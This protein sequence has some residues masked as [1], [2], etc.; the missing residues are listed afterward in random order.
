MLALVFSVTSFLTATLLSAQTPAQRVLLL[1]PNFSGFCL[2]TNDAGQRGRAYFQSYGQ[3]QAKL[4]IDRE[5][6]NWP[7]PDGSPGLSYE[8]FSKCGGS[9]TACPATNPVEKPEWH[10]NLITSITARPLDLELSRCCRI[11][12]TSETNIWLERGTWQTPGTAAKMVCYDGRPAFDECD[13]S[14]TL[15]PS[16]PYLKHWA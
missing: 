11:M 10:A 3:S 1:A 14:W 12:V 13:R 5:E 6:S 4:V 2:Y 9:I 15:N 8:I 7:N 16:L